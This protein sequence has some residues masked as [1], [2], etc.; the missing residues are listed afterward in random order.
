[1]TQRAACMAPAGYRNLFSEVLC[2]ST[3][4]VQAKMTALKAR[5]DAIA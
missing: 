4:D 5:V 3:A 2:K 1:M